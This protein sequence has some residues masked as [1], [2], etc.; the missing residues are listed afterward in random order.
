MAQAVNR[1]ASPRRHWPISTRWANVVVA[2][3][4]DDFEVLCPMAR[5]SRIRFPVTTSTTCFATS[6]TSNIVHV[7]AALG[8][9]AGKIDD[10]GFTIPPTTRKKKKKEKKDSWSAALAAGGGH[11]PRSDCRVGRQVDGRPG[12]FRPGGR[13]ICDQGSGVHPPPRVDNYNLQ[14]MMRIPTATPAQPS[15]QHT[16]PINNTTATTG[17]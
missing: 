11:V 4:G 9:F 13:G 1:A 2:L 12:R 17:A 10:L 6:A 3:T 8:Y 5:M 14:L 15:R 7:P 16:P